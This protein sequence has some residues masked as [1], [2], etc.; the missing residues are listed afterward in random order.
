MEEYNNRKNI[1]L[2]RNIDNIQEYMK[3]V[4]IAISAGGSTLYELCMRNNLVYA[5]LCSWQRPDWRVDS[6]Y[7]VRIPV[8]DSGYFKDCACLT[9]QQKDYKNNLLYSPNLSK[10]SERCYSYYLQIHNILI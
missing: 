5:G 6:T 4:D 9:Y 7:V 8:Y 10:D 1:I 2:L 3:K